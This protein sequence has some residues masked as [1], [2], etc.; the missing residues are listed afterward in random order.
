MDPKKHIT[1]LDVLPDLT[2]REALTLTRILTHLI[3]AIWHAHGVDIA[4]VLEREHEQRAP[5]SVPI[6]SLPNDDDLPF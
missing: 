4:L 2:G 3:D 1:P 5:S 6:T